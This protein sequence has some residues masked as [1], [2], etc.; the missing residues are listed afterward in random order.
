MVGR[1]GFRTLKVKTG[2][3][4]DVDRAALTEIRAAVGPDVQVMI[5]AN[6]S[7]KEDEAL[8]YLKELAELGVTVAEDPCQLRPNRAFEELQAASPL[9][10]LVDRGCTTADEAALFLERGA[11]ALSLPASHREAQ[12]MAELADAQHCAG[13]V[14]F[15]SGASLG[16]LVALQV[17]SALPTRH[18][19]LPTEASFFLMYPEDYFAEPLRIEEGSVHLPET[20]GHARWIDWERVQALQP[21]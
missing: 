16:A 2:Q 6:G 7:Y 3:G 18:Y 8:D 13:H 14:G 9:P 5:D 20:P 19:S 1:H 17:Q 12:R 10:I 11:R 15:S 4:R 21:A